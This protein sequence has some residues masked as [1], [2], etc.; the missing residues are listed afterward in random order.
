[1]TFNAPQIPV[2]NNVDVAAVSDPAAIKDALVRQAARRCAGSR[3]SSIMQASGRRA[4]S[5]ECGPGKVLAGLAKRIADSVRWRCDRPIWPALE[6]AL[7]ATE[8]A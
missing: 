6:A 1:M 2:L 4:M 7:A 8:E 3:P 5:I